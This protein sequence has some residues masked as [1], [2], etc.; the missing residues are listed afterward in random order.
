MKRWM[1]LPLMVLALTS[2]A[3]CSPNDEGPEYTPQNPQTPQT[4]VTP[5]EPGDDDSN[6][7]Q[8]PMKNN[9]LRV[10]VNGRSFTATLLDNAATEA[11][12]ERL[13][14]GTVTLRMDDYGDMEKVGSLGFSLPRNDSRTTTAP[15][16]IVLYQ[17]NSIVIFYGSN[18]WSYTR[19]GKVDGV[20]SREQMLERWG[21]A[22]SA[23]VTLSLEE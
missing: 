22:G 8:D 14:Q 18:T 2:A 5:E 10:S 17:G 9:T 19:L 6:E 15:G 13:A 4:P 12:K 23:D 16:D 11:L 21:A 20:S 3:A 1:M 7:N